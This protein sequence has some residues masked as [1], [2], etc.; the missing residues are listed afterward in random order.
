M[1]SV[2]PSSCVT[3]VAAYW[4]SDVRRLPRMWHRR[5][6]WP[7]KSRRCG[8]QVRHLP[9][10][11]HRLRSGARASSLDITIALHTKCFGKEKATRKAQVVATSVNIRSLLQHG[12][13]GIVRLDCCSTRMEAI[14]TGWRPLLLLVGCRPSLVGWSQLQLGDL[15]SAGTLQDKNRTRGSKGCQTSARAQD[16]ACTPKGNKRHYV[17]FWCPTATQLRLSTLSQEKARSLG[18]D[19]EQVFFCD[20]ARPGT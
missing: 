17:S 16:A 6:P 15:F 14:A 12:N 1:C 5:P 9:L 8:A 2:I 18:K 10:R 19:T 7:L 13:T 11:R 3:P 4:V 20:K